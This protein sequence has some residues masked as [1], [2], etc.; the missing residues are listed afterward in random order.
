MGLSGDKYFSLPG[1]LIALVDGVRRIK[2]DCG[3]S[4][5]GHKLII[6]LLGDDGSSGAGGG[7]S[8]GGGSGSGG[9]CWDCKSVG[10][11]FDEPGECHG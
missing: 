8:Y 10:G 5:T 1:T 4:E 2:A 3:Y 7:G 6:L 9:V 11:A